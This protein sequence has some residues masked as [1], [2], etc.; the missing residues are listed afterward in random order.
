[1]NFVWSFPKYKKLSFTAILLK[2]NNPIDILIKPSPTN[3]VEIKQ[4]LDNINKLLHKL[5]KAMNKPIH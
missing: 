2:H 3:K 1:L 4:Y 5:G